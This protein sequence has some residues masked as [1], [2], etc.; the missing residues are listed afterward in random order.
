[1]N[2]LLRMVA[3][4]TI[5]ALVAARAQTNFHD[6]SQGGESNRENPGKH[7][8]DLNCAPCHEHGVG[9]APFKK[10]LTYMR[11]NAVYNVI[12]KGVMQVQASKLTDTDRRQIVEYLTGE[13]PGETRSTPLPMCADDSS[14]FDP[15]TKANVTGWGVDAKNTRSLSS[16][17]TRLSAVNVRRLRLKWAFAV[18][19]S[20]DV[21]S[22]PLIV[23][24]AL[25]MGSQS[26]AVYALDAIR[27]CIHWVYQ[28]AAD[29]RGGVVYSA[30]SR[31]AVLF[32]DVFAYTYGLD[33][34]TG[35]LLWKTK[36]DGHPAARVVGTPAVW[37]D[38]LYVPVASLG[39]E[40]SSASSDYVCCTF[41]GS[42]VALDRSTGKIVWRRYTIPIAAVEQFRDSVDRPHFGPS[43]AGVWSSPTID[44]GRD[45]LYFATGDNYSEPADGNSD[46]VFAL[47]LGTGEVRWK[48]QALAGDIFNDACY[49][50]QRESNCP[51]KPGPDADFTAPPIMVE[52][53]SGRSILVAGQKSGDIFGLDPDS[54]EPLWRSRISQDTSP[55]SGG[56]WWGMAIRGETLFVPA[57]SVSD[58]RLRPNTSSTQKLEAVDGLYAVN[59]FNGKRVWSAPAES[60]CER[61][62]AC[63]GISAALLTIPGAVLAGSRDGYVRVFDSSTGKQLW[64]FDTAQQF[65]TLSGE[66]AAGGAI[67]GAGAIMAA[68]DTLYAI[69]NGKTDSVLLA[70]SLP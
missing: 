60:Y 21:R 23:G 45:L 35:A 3:A 26:G 19:D 54:G 32:G 31:P 18:P 55:L 46:A 37:K 24:T 2:L 22:Q 40:E 29:V 51:K 15:K 20:V 64:S 47:N 52:D 33:A 12:T 66:L 56:I 65:K 59:A 10:L 61:D 57:F 69:S 16:A 17:S 6:S 63:A 14:W 8:F 27:G 34:S 41:R 25:F 53:T 11:P 67:N 43:G 30:G 49:A 70:F 36:V 58:M 7:L 4:G 44:G 1:V 62:T 39:E 13:T 28:A 38:R 9:G 5:T 68:N 42:I 50:G 48:Y